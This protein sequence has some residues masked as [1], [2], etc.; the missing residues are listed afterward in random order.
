MHAYQRDATTAIASFREAVSLAPNNPV[1]HT[2]LAHAEGMLGNHEEAL[3]ELRRAEQLPIALR[4]SIGITNLAYAYAQNGSPE[5]ARRLVQMLAEK[6]TDRRHHAGHWA[7]AHLAVGDVEAAREALEV[8]IDKIAKEEP[9]AGYL[10]L[11]LIKA[12]I[13]SDPVLDEPE[14]VALRRQL[15]G[16]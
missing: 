1:H 4:S 11:R 14:F 7:L 10:T 3:R 5:D 16:H 13:Y 8:V 12:N 9:D 2:W 15:Q 6:S